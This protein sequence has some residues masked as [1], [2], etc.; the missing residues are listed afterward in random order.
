[1]M[2]ETEIVALRTPEAVLWWAPHFGFWCRLPKRIDAADRDAIKDAVRGE[3]A[4]HEALYQQ[5]LKRC[6]S[7]SGHQRPPPGPY[8][9]SVRS[10]RMPESFFAAPL[11]G[12]ERAA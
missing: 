2:T 9:V 4:T 11:P 12:K 6:G 5:A 7:S 1:M 10:G 8:R 3:L